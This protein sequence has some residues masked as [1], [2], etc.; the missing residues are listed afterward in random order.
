MTDDMLIGTIETARQI[1]DGRYPAPV[2]GYAV[3]LAAAVLDLKDRYERSY[4]IVLWHVRIQR[5]PVESSNITS[6]GWHE[7][8]NVLE[9]EF[10]T[11][12][13]YRYAHVPRNVYE[14]LRDAESKGTF[15]AAQIK[16]AFTATLITPAQRKEAV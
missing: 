10:G 5:Y 7:V 8:G 11:G 6:I 3:L 15:F 14:A 16:R 12:A 9:I 2:P 13:V 1:C 4:D